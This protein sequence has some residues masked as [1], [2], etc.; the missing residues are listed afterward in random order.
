[1]EF[2]C[3]WGMLEKEWSERLVGDGV[4]NGGGGTEGRAEW[5]GNR[6]KG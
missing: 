2:L 5:R 1:M 3:L 6:K 4:G